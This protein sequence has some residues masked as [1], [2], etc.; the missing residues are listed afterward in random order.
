[1]ATDPIERDL[2]GAPREPASL[3]SQ[4]RR[5]AGARLSR[6]LAVLVALAESDMRARYGRGRWQLIKWLVDPFA[7][8]GVYLLL[9]TFVLNRPVPRPGSASPAPS[10]PSSS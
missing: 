1:M 10:F 3:L 5:T 4:R 2:I 6:S 7:V 9:V 8:A